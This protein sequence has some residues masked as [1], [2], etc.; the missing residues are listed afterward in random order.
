MGLPLGGEYGG[1]FLTDDYKVYGFEG[2][3]PYLEKIVDCLGIL[4]ER[5]EMIAEIHAERVIV[6]GEKMLKIK[7]LVGFRSENELPAEYL[8]KPPYMQYVKCIDVV[9]VQL[10]REVNP[11]RLISAIPTGDKFFWIEEDAIITNDMMT[12]MLTWAKICGARLAKINKRLSKE[13][14]EWHGEIMHKI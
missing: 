1:I 11:D 8:R 3:V 4:G 14:I 10:P 9:T 12:E 13:N 2:T 7:K 6:R 5:K